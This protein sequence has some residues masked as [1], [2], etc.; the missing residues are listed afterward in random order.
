MMI[1]Q[2]LLK[3]NQWLLRLL[4]IYRHMGFWYSIDYLGHEYKVGTGRV[5]RAK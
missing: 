1:Q 5:P 3:E 2:H 4:V